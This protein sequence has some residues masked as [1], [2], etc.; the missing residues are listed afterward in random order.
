MHPDREEPVRTTI[1]T[2]AG[3]KNAGLKMEIFGRNER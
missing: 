1:L 2:E 3:E